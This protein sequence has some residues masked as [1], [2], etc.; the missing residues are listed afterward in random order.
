MKKSCFLFK[1]VPVSD[2]M[3]NIVKNIALGTVNIVILSLENVSGDVVLGTMDTDVCTTT[4]VNEHV[5]YSIP[6]IRIPIDRKKYWKERIIYEYNILMRS[7]Y[8]YINLVK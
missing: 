5:F 8:R 3:G 4:E 1:G 2:Y 6:I 7:F